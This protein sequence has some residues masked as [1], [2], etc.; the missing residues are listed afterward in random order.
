MTIK[1]RTETQ[2]FRLDEALVVRRSGAYD[3][4][5]TGPSPKNTSLWAR[6][7]VSTFPLRFPLAYGLFLELR[8][9][10]HHIRRVCEQGHVRPLEMGPTY[11]LAS[12]GVLVRNKRTR[13][14]S[15][16][17]QTLLSDLPWLSPEN[18]HLFLLGWDAGFRC[19]AHEGTLENRDDMQVLSS[20]AYPDGVNSMPRSA[21]P[22]ST[23]RDRLAPLPSRE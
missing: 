22:Q 20:S 15:R 2:L 21:V 11:Q 14:R 1:T 3:R 4:V 19:H 9:A 5:H 6:S 13:S 8:S 23:R 12:L 18:L 7:L 17:M 16:D 10:L